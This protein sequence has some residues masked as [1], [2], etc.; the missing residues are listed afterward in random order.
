[1]FNFSIINAMNKLTNK[2][3]KLIEKLSKKVDF[4]L[5]LLPFKLNYAGW[6]NVIAPLSNEVWDLV[7]RHIVN[8]FADEFKK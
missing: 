8:N 1:M 2:H 4:Q 7:N 3:I 5:P 6:S